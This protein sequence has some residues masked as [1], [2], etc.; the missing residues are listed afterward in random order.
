MLV[1]EDIRQYLIFKHNPELYLKY[2]K[3]FYKNCFEVYSSSKYV[4]DCAT[5]IIHDLN[6]NDKVNSQIDHFLST[7][8]EQSDEDNFKLYQSLA[9]DRAKYMQIGHY[10]TIISNHEQLEF[11]SKDELKGQ[12]CRKLSL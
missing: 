12:L 7:C 5:G 4:E 6:I 10:P 11:R 8:A 1:R 3:K 9:L 2:V